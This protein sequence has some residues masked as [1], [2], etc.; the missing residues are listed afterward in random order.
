MHTYCWIGAQPFID[1]TTIHTHGLHEHAVR[2]GFI[3]QNIFE[4]IG[5]VYEPRPLVGRACVHLQRIYQ[6][7]MQ[8]H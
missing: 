7:R 8:I 2:I 5:L 4:Y 1:L 3:K 6:L